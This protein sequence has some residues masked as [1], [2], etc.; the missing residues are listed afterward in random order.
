MTPD[1]V[2]HTLGHLSTVSFSLALVGLGREAPAA[3]YGVEQSESDNSNHSEDDEDEG[4]TVI[5][6]LEGERD[7]VS[8]GNTVRLAAS[9]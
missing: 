1:V 2:R 7:G 3:L 6:G 4:S 8:S 5:H 9:G